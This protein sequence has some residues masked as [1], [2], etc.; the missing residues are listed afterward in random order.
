MATKKADS[1]RERRER[2]IEECLWAVEEEV[3][4]MSHSDRAILR[5][6]FAQAMDEHLRDAEG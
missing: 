4:E 3:V 2:V 1:A 6:R 5:I